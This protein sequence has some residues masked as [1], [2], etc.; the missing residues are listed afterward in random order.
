MKKLVTRYY[1]GLTDFVHSQLFDYTAGIFSFVGW[2]LTESEISD[3]PLS[4]FTSMDGSHTKAGTMFRDYLIP[5][6]MDSFIMYIDVE[7]NPWEEPVE[8]TEEELY[9]AAGPLFAK[10]YRWALESCEK[11]ELLISEYESAKTK[12]MDKLSSDSLTLFNDTPQAGGDFT[13]DNYVTNATKV[14]SSTE[15]ATPIERLREIQQK[16]RNLYADWA[17]EFSK[18]V[19]YSAE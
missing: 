4:T 6:F 15:V 8:P 13:T 17:D 3:K 12:L 1:Y 5:E 16:I 14:T 10:I 9:E 7:S 2:V 19:I 18:Y 11:Y